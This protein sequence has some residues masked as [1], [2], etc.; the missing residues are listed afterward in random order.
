VGAANAVSPQGLRFVPDAFVFDTAN[1]PEPGGVEFVK[2]IRHPKVPIGIRYL[3]DWDSKNNLQIDRMDVVP[4]FG[5]AFPEFA[6]VI[7]S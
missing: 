7:N 2:F 6:C 1:Q 5:I 3:R 4:L